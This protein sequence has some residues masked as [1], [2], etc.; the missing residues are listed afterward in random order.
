M[1]Q[2]TKLSHCSSYLSNRHPGWILIPRETIPISLTRRIRKKTHREKTLRS[3]SLQLH[4]HSGSLSHS[5]PLQLIL[6]RWQA[7]T[8]LVLLRQTLIKILPKIPTNQKWQIK[9]L[10]NRMLSMLPSR[11]KTF[12][13]GL[14]VLF[15]ASRLEMRTL[16]PW[17]L[18]VFKRKIS[19]KKR[20]A[21]KPMKTPQ[22]SSR[23]TKIWESSS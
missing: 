11:L 20:W 3:S 22:I 7:S 9:I 23:K 14:K 1:A 8:R 4:K 12:N 21:R 19:S 6:N 10:I 5:C 13:L 16:I 17:I 15:T 18:H 2:T